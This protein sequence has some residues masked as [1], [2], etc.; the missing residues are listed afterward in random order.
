VLLPL[1][2]HGFPVGV[3]DSLG[4][5]LELP[6][7]FGQTFLGQ[8]FQEAEAFVRADR[9]AGGPGLVGRWAVR[10]AWLGHGVGLVDGDREVVPCPHAGATLVRGLHGNPGFQ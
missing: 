10:A 6:G 7:P 3:G 5:L 1:G 9:L 8:C 4:R 2:P